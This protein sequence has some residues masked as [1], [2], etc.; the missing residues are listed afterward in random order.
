MILADS[1]F[2]LGFNLALTFASLRLCEST[3][4]GQVGASTHSQSAITTAVGIRIEAADCGTP[5]REMD[6]APNLG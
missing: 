4:F 6:E 5:G 1:S 2:N 3:S